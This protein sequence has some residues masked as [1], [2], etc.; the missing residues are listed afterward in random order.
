MVHSCTHIG[1]LFSAA[2]PTR[3][4]NSHHEHLCKQL[5]PCAAIWD[6]I[7]KYLGFEANEID[8]IRADPLAQ[9]NV[10]GSFMDT[11]VAKWSLWAPGDYRGSTDFATLEALK[12]AVDKAGAADI[13]QSLTLH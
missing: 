1:A 6:D 9:I 3:V 2:D 4:N 13:A 10:P 7:A 12:T 5:R 8:N 11:I